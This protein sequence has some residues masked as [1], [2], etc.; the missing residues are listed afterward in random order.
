[1]RWLFSSE[2][3]TKFGSPEL[4]CL[5]NTDTTAVCG[6]AHNVERWCMLAVIN[7][8]AALPNSPM[9]ST[10]PDSGEY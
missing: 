10:S 8:S 2:C 1:M 4:Y 5:V 3:A 6:T 9:R 7:Q